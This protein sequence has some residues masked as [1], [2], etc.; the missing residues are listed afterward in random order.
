M[1]GTTIGRYR[2]TEKLGEGG[3]GVVY[4]A[5]DPQLERFVALKL[6]RP[7]VVDPSGLDRLVRE[8]RAV[9]ALTHP[10]IVTVY[11]FGAHAEVNYLAMEFVQGRM[12]DEL[13]AAKRGLGIRIA[14]DYA[15]QIAGALAHA[16]AC[17]IVHRDLKPSNVMVSD[18]GTVKVLDFG[19]AKGIEPPGGGSD[20]HGATVSVRDVTGAGVIVGTVAYM[21][22][23]QAEGLKVDARSDIFAFGAVLFEMLSG[24]RAFDGDTAMSTLAAILRGEPRRL[25]AVGRTVPRELEEIVGRCMRKDRARRAQSIAD[26][27]VALE[28]VREG[29]ANLSSSAVA[30]LPSVAPSRHRR[31]VVGLATAGLLVI[32]ASVAASV[33]WWRSAGGPAGHRFEFARVTADPGLTLDPVV[34]PTGSLLAYASDRG[35][36]SNLDIWVQPLRGGNAVRITNDPADD[37]SPSF[38]PDGSQIAFRSERGG[39]GIF[40]AGALGGGERLVAP[41]GRDPRFSPEGRWIAFVTG[42]R[43]GLERVH[44]VAS[45]GGPVLTVPRDGLSAKWPFWSPDGTHLVVFADDKGQADWW[46]VPIGPDGPAAA[47]AM[48]PTTIRRTLENHG[49][50]L[51]PWLWDAPRNRLLAVGGTADV[52]NIWQLPVLDPGALTIGRPEQ[53]TSG[54]GL[55]G[56][57]SVDPEGRLFFS[58]T[59][60]RINLWAQPIDLRTQ[61]PA[62]QPQQLTDSAAADYWPSSSADGRRIAFIST[63]GGAADVWVKDLVT[64]EERGLTATPNGERTAEISPDGSRVAYEGPTDSLHLVHVKDGL[65]ET[66]CQPCDRGVWAWAPDGTRLLVGH[67]RL[68]VLDLPSRKVT[69]VFAHKTDALWIGRFAPDGRHVAFI[70]WGADNRV[71]EIVAP[72]TGAPVPQEAWFEVTA[73]DAVDEESA[74][75][76]VDGRFLFFASER[77]GARCLYARELEAGTRRPTGPLLEVQHLHRTRRAMVD[78]AGYPARIT[79]AGEKL[80]FAMRELSGNVWSATRLPLSRQP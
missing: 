71:R 29:L 30:A 45:T 74:F 15:I 42:G 49:I 35:D 44:V 4:K 3:M 56:S 69:D 62:G 9:S 60:P 48:R 22:P 73:G 40:V 75:S 31:L 21:S 54:V 53:I 28:D 14:L 7:G 18:D 23:E 12:L 80:V 8:A 39:G 36:A 25:S 11:E 38:S 13:I 17:G 10:S 47:S 50:A 41:Q 67:R 27:K 77:D 26:V 61:R 58:S 55:N 51:L 24:E 6:L 79:F 63:R 76:P 72:F 64:G 70:A 34:A 68:Q 57:P 65:T 43:G 37:R 5:H 20:S 46:L 52:G 1:V 19:L 59:T 33:L 16:H 32:G 78:T 2:V 66:L